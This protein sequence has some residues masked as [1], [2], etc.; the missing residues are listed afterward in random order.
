MKTLPTLLLTSITMML[1]V[2]ISTQANADNN[3]NELSTCLVKATNAEQRKILT[4]WAYISLGKNKAL[5][6]FVKVTPAQAEALNQ[7]TAQTFMQLLT[8]SCRNE[9]RHTMQQKGIIGVQQSFSALAE[10]AG[11]EL[12][13]SPEVTLGLVDMSKYIDV[14]K[15]LLL[16]Y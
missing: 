14:S 10:V 13:A 11:K 7:Q 16:T 8:Q 1:S 15:L 2:L 6:E 12:L 3:N 5:S 4:Q 9:V